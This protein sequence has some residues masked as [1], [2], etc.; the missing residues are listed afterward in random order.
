MKW[1]AML[2]PQDL[3]IALYIILIFAAFISGFFLGALVSPARE[4]IAREPWH[5][6]LAAAQGEPRH[7]GK[8][9]SMNL[10]AV[11]LALVVVFGVIVIDQF[12]GPLFPDAF[13]CLSDGGTQPPRMCTGR[14]AVIAKSP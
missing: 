13:Y 6:R 5:A 3:L 11:V 1:L 8:K 9:R 4:R 2:E 7:D 10:P 12:K 14:I